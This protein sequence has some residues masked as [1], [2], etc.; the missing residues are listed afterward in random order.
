M[1]VLNWFFTSGVHDP[2]WVQ[3]ISSLTLVLL[4]VVTLL[5]LFQYARDTHSLA[6]STAEQ[7]K[8]AQA[9]FLALVR[10]EKDNPH[11]AGSLASFA[12]PTY[13]QWSIENQGNGSAI[14]IY[15]ELECIPQSNGKQTKIAE[16]LNPIPPGG[17]VPIKVQSAEK[18][19][20]CQIAYSSLGGRRFLTDVTST[21]GELTTKFYPY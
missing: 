1:R 6:R 21:N 10:I 4:T 16:S 3:A 18:V 2:V 15:I 5:V 19:Q 7:L 20:S 17:N 13:Y 14:N 12:P 8:N 11:R 9:P